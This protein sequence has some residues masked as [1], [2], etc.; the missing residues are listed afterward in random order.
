MSIDVAGRRAT[1]IAK[2]WI[3]VVWW[4]SLLLGAVIAIAFLLSPVL[5]KR[6]S[7]LE[8]AV[9][10]SVA[11]DSVARTLPL[12]SADTLRVSRAVVEERERTYYLEF[13]TTAWGLVFMTHW[14]FLP[15]IG[16]MILGLHL[17]RS[18]LADV[19]AAEVFT[20]QNAGRLSRLGWL[21]IVLGIV[22]PPLEYLRSWMVLARTRLSGVALTPAEWE[23]NEGVVSLGV[24]LLVLASAWRY[25][26]ELQ[27][28][29]D[30][31]V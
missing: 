12:V 23:W 26:A 11:D 8:I 17:V 25:G 1:R 4:L 22:G 6:G 3:D 14:L 27:Q 7:G 24:L 30:L 29:R 15:A 13:Q 18:F 10:V 21:T 5:V 9:R 19:L 28:E 16:G 2:V 31:T 20:R